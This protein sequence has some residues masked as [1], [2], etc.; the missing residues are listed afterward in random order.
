VGI[1]LAISGG[2]AF[3]ETMGRRKGPPQLRKTDRCPV[4]GMFVKK[5]PK[6]VAQIDY[7]DGSY[8]LFDGPKDLFKF[9]FNVKFYEPQRSIDDVSSMYVT[10]YYSVEF[11]DAK[12]AFFVIGSDVYGP[13]GHEL[14][15]HK[16]RASAEEFMADHKGTRILTFDEVTED[17]VKGLDKRS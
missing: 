15:P 7:R 13:M 16:D 2:T 10:D 5:Y 3:A 11:L 14:I 1:V 6:W 4:C 12:Q 8:T 9:Y 17:V